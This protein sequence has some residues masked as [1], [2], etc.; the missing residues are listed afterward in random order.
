[1]NQRQKVLKPFFILTFFTS[2]FLLL[3]G[4]QINNV[5]IHRLRAIMSLDIPEKKYEYLDHTADVQ[6][7]AWGNSLKESFEQIAMSMFGYMTDIETVEMLSSETIEFRMDADDDILNF[8]FKWLDEWLFM[9]S[10]EPFFIPRKIE[11]K[12]FDAEKG[13]V[14]ATGY[15]EEFKL[16]KHPQ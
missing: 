3:P 10:A 13:Y 9:F 15:G 2:S 5:V 6:L 1:L 14:K 8:L 4:I 12:E 16:G 7:H 11:I